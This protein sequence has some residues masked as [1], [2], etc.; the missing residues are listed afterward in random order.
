[1]SFGSHP[2]VKDFKQIVDDHAEHFFIDFFNFWLWQ[3]LLPAFR[4]FL[5]LVLSRG[6]FGLLGLFL[7]GKRLL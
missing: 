5:F 7:D 2:K 1:L 3:D 4:I 6:V